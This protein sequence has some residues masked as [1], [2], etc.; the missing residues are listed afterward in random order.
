MRLLNCAKHRDATQSASQSGG[1]GRGGDWE[2]AELQDM[3]TWTEGQRCELASAWSWIERGALD[4]MPELEPPS[5]STSENDH[6]QRPRG[7]G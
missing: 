5:G 6:A 7:G 4:V 3:R 1:G 2:D